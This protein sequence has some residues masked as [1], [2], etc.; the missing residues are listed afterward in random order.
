MLADEKYIWFNDGKLDDRLVAKM[1]EVKRLCNLP[2]SP[3]NGKFSLQFASSYL[4]LMQKF[5]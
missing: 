5:D 1:E 3:M 2:S 4:K